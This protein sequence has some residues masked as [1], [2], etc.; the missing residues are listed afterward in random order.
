MHDDVPDDG[1]EV[2]K[3]VRRGYSDHS[4]AAILKPAITR[5]IA[6]RPI[7]HVMRHSV[8]L[9]PDLSGVTVEIENVRAAWVLSSELK[10]GGPIP[11]LPPQQTLGKGQRAPE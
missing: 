9:D 10:T 5:R 1:I 4:D 2:F 7:A 6:T 8:N 11:K 3:D